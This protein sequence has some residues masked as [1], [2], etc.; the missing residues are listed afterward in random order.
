MTMEEPSHSEGGTTEAIQNGVVTDLTGLLRLPGHDPLTFRDSRDNLFEAFQSV[1]KLQKDLIDTYLA[2][3]AKHSGKIKAMHIEQLWR[4]VPTQLASAI[5]G[6]GPKF[7]F[8]NAVPGF[9]GYRQISGPLSWLESTGLLLRTFI[10]EKAAVPLASYRKENRFKLYL[11]DVGILHAMI[12]LP[13]EVILDYGFGGYKGY[14]AENFVAQELRASGLS[15]LY[16]WQGRTSEVD[17]LMETPRGI[18][19]VEVK[20]GQV[21]QSKS[22]R[23]FVDK[24]SPIRS[25]V[26][27]GRNLKSRGERYRIPIYSAGMFLPKLAQSLT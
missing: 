16:C 15:N 10:V 7:R 20:S 24:Y 14:V 9:R 27:S 11:F 4:N 8:K 22:L 18:I 2:D 25:V 6:S 26:V 21:T 3:I 12:D 5:D 19:P 13:A 17:F 23:V 1:R